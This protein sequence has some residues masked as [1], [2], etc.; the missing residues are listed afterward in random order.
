MP[1]PRDSTGGDLMAA[2]G[3]TPQDVFTE[4]TAAPGAL[5]QPL[6]GVTVAGVR[7]D[8][9]ARSFRLRFPLVTSAQAL[10]MRGFFAQQQGAFRAFD[11]VSPLDSRIY[12]VRFAS[13]MGIEWFDVAALRAGT[14]LVF[15]VV[16]D[17]RG[18]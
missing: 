18:A 17:D 15:A 14:E 8:T 2:W 7:T 11:F 5:V 6:G 13:A 12:Q 9:M 16:D 3:W 4:T 1:V 10:D